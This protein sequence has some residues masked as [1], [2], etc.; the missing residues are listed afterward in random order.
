MHIDESLIDYL[1]TLSCLSLSA[2]EKSKLK[3]DM[4]SILGYMSKLAQ[5]DTEGVPERSHPFDH[6]NGF[7][8]D[9]V[10]DSLDRELLLQNAPSTDGQGFIVPKMME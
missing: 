9:V 1:E 4:E 5:L 7:R 3:A 6:I 10:Q 2:N 8:E